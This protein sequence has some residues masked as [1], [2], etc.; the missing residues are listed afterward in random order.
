[1]SERRER[2]IAA[3][4]RIFGVPQQD[5]PTIMEQQVGPVFAT[6]PSQRQAEQRGLEKRSPTGTAQSL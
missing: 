6:R 5:V 2:G 1:M 4:A 3:Y